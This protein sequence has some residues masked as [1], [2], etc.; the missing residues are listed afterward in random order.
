MEE[1][2]ERIAE[3]PSGDSQ[4]GTAARPV[5][6][7]WIL[8]TMALIGL[9]VGGV[10]FLL[11]PRGSVLEPAEAQAELFESVA[12]PLPYGLVATEARRLPS[13]EVVLTYALDEDAAG[14]GP[15]QVT[16]M[17]FPEQRAESVLEDQFQKLRFETSDRGGGR[18][19]GGRGRG[20]RGGGG[21]GDP[22]DGK[23]SGGS[24]KPKLQDAGFLDWQGFSANYAR[25]QHT[26]SEDAAPEGAGPDAP[27]GEESSGDAPVVAGP[28]IEAPAGDKPEGDA[29]KGGKPK[30]DAKKPKTYD[31]VRVNLSTGGRCIIAYVRFPVGGTGSKEVV[32]ELLESF[33]PLN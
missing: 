32:A 4:P 14:D 19:R 25:L 10:L 3:A 16:F 5:S 33:E 17:Q 23:M 13:R 7:L 8:G 31:T 27:D 22:G 28:G 30:G 15:M 12:D 11:K 21:G 2:G 24:S 20:G 1:H 6:S 26:V 18:G 9:L 29:P